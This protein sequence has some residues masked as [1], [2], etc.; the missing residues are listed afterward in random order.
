MKPRKK[1]KSYFKTRHSQY[2]PSRKDAK[3]GWRKLKTIKEKFKL[4]YKLTPFENLYHR[5]LARGYFSSIEIAIE[6]EAP[7]LSVYRL[8]HVSQI[9]PEPDIRTSDK[10]IFYYKDYWK[11][12][13]ICDSY[14]YSDKMRV[15]DG[16]HVDEIGWRIRK[17]YFTEYFSNNYATYRKEYQ[18]YVI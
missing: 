10:Y 17:E 8:A 7:I 16:T 15:H 5:H 11:F 4:R 3:Y 1:F 6:I 14:K 13:L 18:N 2:S 12:K 9:F